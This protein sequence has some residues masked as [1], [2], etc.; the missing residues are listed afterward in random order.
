MGHCLC[1]GVKAFLDQESK[2]LSP[3]DF[4]GKWMS[5]LEPAA[6]FRCDPVEREEDPQLAMEYAGV[7]QSLLNLRTFPCVRI[8]EEKGRLSLHGTWFDIGSGEMRV[9]DTRTGKF[10]SAAE[11]A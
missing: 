9:L 11:L 5:L 10:R 3:G 7:R 8:L 1:G 2:P 4:I 6:R